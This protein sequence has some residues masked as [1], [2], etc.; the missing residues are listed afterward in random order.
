L[1]LAETL[2]ERREALA[3]RGAAL[4]PR[5]LA[6]LGVVALVG[7]IAAVGDPVSRA[8]DEW[9]EFKAS[10]APAASG[11]NRLLQTGGARYD[12][13][14]VSLNDLADAPVRGVGAGNWNLSWYQSRR[15]GDDTRQ[16]HSVVFQ[17]LAELGLLGGLALALAVGAVLAALVLRRREAESFALL[18]GAGGMFA[19]WL[20]HTSVDWMHILPGITLS[21]LCGAAALLAPWRGPSGAR[22]AASY[23]VPTVAVVVAAAGFLTVG[24]VLRAEHR[25]TDG[26]ELL[27]TDPPGA[28]AK[29]G[30]ALA[31]NRDAIPAL[32]LRSA[33]YA[34]VNDFV[35]AKAA[36]LE[37]AKKEPGNFVTWQLLGDLQIR[38]E[39]GRGF[40]EAG[41]AP[42]YRRA[43]ELNPRD[44]E[45]R[46][47]AKFPFLGH[48]EFR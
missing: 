24:K 35:N 44:A 26:Q 42:F 39:V 41:A 46:D 37:A 4:S 18:I 11:G 29:A 38:R 6:G 31:L 8:D 16:P 15:T 36:L 23:V 9:Q 27:A 30:D 1:A 25:I 20:L 43:L 7:V 3:A 14:R 32:Y 10:S 47:L 19:T 28:N 34:Q 2:L 13:W 48:P 21:A 17:T 40:D 12:Y 33:A 22:G 5:I 45:L